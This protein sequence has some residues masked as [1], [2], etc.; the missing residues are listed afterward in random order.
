MRNRLIINSLATLVIALIVASP[1]SA[2]CDTI[3]GPVV[4]AAQKALQTGNVNLALI[5]VK[6]ER[7]AEIKAAFQEALAVRRLNTKARELADRYFFETLVRLH[8]AGEGEPYTGLRAAGSDLGPVIPVV[9][10]AIDEGSTERLVKLFPSAL[11]AEVLERFKAVIAR[12]QFKANDVEAGRRYVEA[13]VSLMH[14]AEETY[15]S[16]ATGAHH[17]ETTHPAPSEIK[18]GDAMEFKIPHSLKAEH[19]ELHAELVKAT[20]AG[21]ETAA[22]ASEVASLLHPHFVKEEAYAMPQLGLLT[23]LAIGKVTPDMMRAIEMSEKLK[24]D[25]PHMLEE[26]RLI[27]VALKHLIAAA[28]KEGKTEHAQF[29]RK[30]MLHAETEEEV[31]YPA[32]I[33]VGQ[34]LKAKARE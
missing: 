14:Y 29:A 30:L 22:A 9:D 3:D 7:E 23:A 5:W 26:H 6:K 2:H 25:L 31:F 8:R 11:P 28:E 21:G 34:Y 13:Y 18:G 20:Q 15:E 10:K 4:K 24:A 16:V 27:V 32:S 17:A 19:D 1:V 33:L 12:K